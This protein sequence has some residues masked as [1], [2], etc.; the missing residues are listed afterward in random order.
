MFRILGREGA[1]ARMLG[2]LFKVVVLAVFLFGSELL[3]G[4]PCSSMTL[5]GFQHR[6]SYWMK[7]KKPHI[8]PSEGW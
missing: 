8:R 3:G 1:N 2:N 4:D 5:G 6:V 7:G